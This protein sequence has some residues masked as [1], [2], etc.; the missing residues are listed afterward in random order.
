MIENR[1]SKTDGAVVADV[2]VGGMQFVDINKLA[3]SRKTF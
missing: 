1:S 3:G 2:H